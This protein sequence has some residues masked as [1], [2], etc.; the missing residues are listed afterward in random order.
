MKELVLSLVTAFPVFL[1]LTPGFI[2][3]HSVDASSS[4]NTTNFDGPAELP[5][6][7]VKS[8][9]KDTPAHGKSWTAHNSQ[10]LQQALTNASCG[11]AIQLDAGVTFSGTFTIPK[12]PCDDSHWII[13]R[14]NAP[15]SSLPGENTRMTPCYGGVESLPARPKLSCGR[16]ANV[17]AKIQFDGKGS[18]P[19]V[20]AEGANHYRLMGLEVTRGASAAGVRNLIE[21]EGAADH[22]VFDR[23]WIHGTAQ[24]D[25]TRGIFLSGSRY[26]AIV[27]SFFTDFH[28][29]A[30]SG[31][32]TD[33]QAIAGGVGRGPMGPYKIANN[34][35]EA[36]SENIIFGGGPADGPPGD[37]EVVRN[38]LFKPLIWM[39]GQPGYIGAADGNPFVV[40][41]LFELK[42]AQRVLLDGNILENSWGGFSQVG[43]AI[44]LT[45]KNPG[46]IHPCAACEV[47]DV[48]IRYNYICHVGAGFQIANIVPPKSGAVAR[49]GQRYSIHDVVVDDIDGGKYA[50][51]GEFAQISMNLGAPVLQN[52]TI[53]HVTAFPGHTLFVIGDLSPSPPMNNFVF[54]NSIVTA[55]QY[56]VWTTGGGPSNCA[57][58]N[59][60][61]M[62]LKACFSSYSFT[63]NV[64]IGVPPSFPPSLWPPGNHFPTSTQEVK[65]VNQHHGNVGDYDLQ[66]SS[67]YKHGGTDGKDVGAD[68]AAIQSAIASVE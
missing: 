40:K 53:S 33:A 22:I 44:L 19:L 66:P 41:N 54:T 20:L 27:D 24:E 62:T 10:T 21:F 15:D 57:Y 23:M 42:N 25:T 37:I 58:P 60:P 28:C 38:H 4:S 47:T 63:N 6:E 61:L 50:G 9:L 13:L 35:L 12:K 45:P 68:T 34:F 52:I 8:A 55:G 59:K 51:A 11:D 65:F 49:D 31:S 2:A 1:F 32:C 48:T 26:V 3:A 56:P 18:G 17:L 7:H 64:I 30:K 14:T 67:R 43:F 39:K 5:R 36:S 16:T 46:G 29:A